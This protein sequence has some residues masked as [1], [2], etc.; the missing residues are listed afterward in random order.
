M[1]DDG[2]NSDRTDDLDRTDGFDRADVLDRTDDL[3][4]T[5]GFDRADD[6]A[7]FEERSPMTWH[8]LAAEQR[9]EW[10]QRL[11]S[12]VCVLRERY[13]LAVR[14]GWWADELQVEVLAAF[15]AWVQRYDSGEWD[16]PPGK[17]ALLFDLER[18]GAALRDGVE[19]F[20]PQRDRP[21]FE[22][23]LR[24]LGCRPPPNA[25]AR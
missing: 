17:L 1:T 18:V 13:R 10:F 11:W 19:P 9:W 6:A 7:G 20:H 21:T 16:D 8:G 5:D 12:D 25:T 4:R 22:R 23:H 2:D 15:A 3:D 14:S 24:M